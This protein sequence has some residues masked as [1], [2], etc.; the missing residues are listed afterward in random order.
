MANIVKTFTFVN[1][2]PADATQVNK[3]FDDLL[4]GINADVSATDKVLGR[5]TAGAGP[6]EEIPCT[7]AGRAILDDANA[8]AQIATLGAA[9]Y[10]EGT[11]TPVLE[12]LTVVGAAPALAG[13]YKR[14]GNLVFFTCSIS[15]GSGGNTS[16]ACPPYAYIEGLPFSVT[17]DGATCVVITA[18]SAPVSLGSGFVGGGS[19]TRFFPASFSAQTVTILI[20]ATYSV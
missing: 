3:N 5:A 7:A 1:S 10:S 6:V 15:A 20:S 11:W 12:G 4:A 16:V 9:A 17:G 14:I 18:N 13:K 19:T 2:Q 8:T